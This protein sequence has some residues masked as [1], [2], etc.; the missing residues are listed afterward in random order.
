MKRRGE[1]EDKS[2]KDKLNVQVS[3]ERCKETY[4]I[5][6]KKKTKV[7]FKRQMNCLEGGLMGMYKGI[8]SSTGRKYKKLLNM[9]LRKI[10]KE[11]W[12]E[13]WYFRNWW[14]GCEESVD[15]DNIDS[16]KDGENVWTW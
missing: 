3:K 16:N 11:W 8:G 2:K 1:Q 4:L 6:K 12:S 5:R 14:N 9:R 10:F 13:R 7:S 15:L